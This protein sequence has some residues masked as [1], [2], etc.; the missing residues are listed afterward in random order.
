[1]LGT[2]ISSCCYV[3]VDIALPSLRRKGQNMSKIIRNYDGKEIKANEVLVPTM[4]D[5]EFAKA[6][7]TN[8]DCIRTITVAGRKFK[9]MY[10]AVSK[11]CEKAAKSSFN[12]CVNEALGHYTVPNSVSMDSLQDDYELNLVTTPSP[13]EISAK[14]EQYQETLDKLV[15]L[16]K[17]LIEKSPKHGL[18]TLLRMFEV[19]GK[20]FQEEL[21]LG[22]DAANTVRKQVDEYLAQGLGNIDID[23]IKSRKSKNNDLYKEKAYRI[24][25]ELIDMYQD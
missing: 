12:L 5:E 25:Y 3:V 7:C 14:K 20:E 18:A 17:S 19:K 9:V 8:P 1:M 24:L 23:G 6:Y 2:Q 13:D 16:L 15:S 4:Y 11:E 22:H 10:V 21:N